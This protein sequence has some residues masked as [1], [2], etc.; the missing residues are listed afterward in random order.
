MKIIDLHTDFILGQANLDKLFGVSTASQINAEMVESADVSVILAGFS[1]DDELGKTELMLSETEK[2]IKNSKS[3]FKVLPHIEGAQIFAKNPKLLE[4]YIS[5]GLKSVGLAH[6][7]DNSLCGSSSSSKNLGL[8]PKGVKIIK[9]AVKDGLLID[10]A[11]MSSESLMQTIKLVGKPPIISHTACFGVE[12]NPRNT[13]DSQ[14]KLVSKLGGVIGIFFS[15][16]Y[17]NSSSPPTIND[18]ANHI[19]HLVKVGGIDVA[20]IGSDFGG[21]T[22]GV[23]KGLENITKL[24]DLLKVLKKR[25]YKKEDLEKIAYKNAHRVLSN[26]LNEQ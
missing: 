26:Y 17:I 5:K 10:L 18:V 22:T 25:G 24:K 9:R 16:K 1:Y 11:H 6:T 12:P 8:S 15:G 13:K 2:F 20:A 21:I 23:P 3:N 7:H 19:D 14:I 4:E